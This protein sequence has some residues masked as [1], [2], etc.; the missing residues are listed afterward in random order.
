MFFKSGGSRAEGIL[1]WWI[2]HA[3]SGRIWGSPQHA[4]CIPRAIKLPRD[5]TEL[6]ALAGMLIHKWCSNETAVFEDIPEDDR[7]TDVHLE[8]G[9]LHTIKTWVFFGSPM[10]MFLLFILYRHQP[11]KSLQKEKWLVW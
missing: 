1:L 9:Q 8:N 5:L 2:L 10:M 11:M 3:L 4:V 6:F 7:V